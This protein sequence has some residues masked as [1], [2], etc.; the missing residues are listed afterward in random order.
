MSN[1]PDVKK[2]VNS[3]PKKCP[4]TLSLTDRLQNRSTNIFGKPNIGN[5]LAS[6]VQK[7]EITGLLSTVCTSDLPDNE[8]IYRL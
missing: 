4:N 5:R 8:M 2:I 6:L 7:N 1:F 3:L